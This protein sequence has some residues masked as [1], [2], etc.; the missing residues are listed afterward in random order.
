MVI[1]VN[2]IKKLIS[3]ML[4]IGIC[5]PLS[6]CW[7]YRGLN[8]LSVFTG[9]AIDRN[10]ENNNYQLTIEFIDFS[11]TSKKEPSKSQLIEVEGKTIF[12]AIRNAKRKL[13]KKLYMGDL[14]VVIISNQIAREE[15]I[16][17]ILDFFTRDAEMR[18][19]VIPVLSQEKTAKEVLMANGVDNKI[20]SEDLE[21][22]I[23]SG[24]KTTAS[25]KNVNICKTFN[26]LH[27]KDEIS[28]VLPAVHCKNNKEKKIVE[29]NGTAIFKG[30]KLQGYLSPEETYTYLL[31][32]NEINRGIIT[33]P[34]ND[35]QDKIVLELEKNKTKMS[36]SYN[37]NR[38][39]I[40]LDMSS[41][42]KVSEV[43]F[44]IDLSKR[45]TIEEF[46]SAAKL[47]SLQ[48]LESL[49]N[50]G[51]KELNCDIL[52]VGTMIHKN[53]PEL[54]YKLR[55]DWD[56]YIQTM[57]VEIRHDFVITNTGLTK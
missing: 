6:G 21:R 39:K 5:I 33:V 48:R 9:I 46:R 10:E 7:N 25:S 28:L 37:E 15:G 14:K 42:V 26:V 27:G 23:K 57:E 47:Q 51:K 19:T 49:I 32:T 54:W 53:D 30:D 50:K 35:S 43:N 3:I 36:Y 17:S 2:V 22:I 31:A 45:E 1:K 11:E 44:D 55:E 12:E 29:L 24:W 18:E 56:Y 13:A 40:F 52:G 4:I 34:L 41:V 8:T 20:V 38:L 16:N